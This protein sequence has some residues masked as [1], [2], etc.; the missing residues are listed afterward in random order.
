[1][2]HLLWSI[3]G[4]VDFNPKWIES[5]VYS[6][7]YYY[8]TFRPVW[9]W[10]KNTLCCI[11]SSG[12]VLVHSGVVQAKQRTVHIHLH[13][14]THLLDSCVYSSAFVCKKL[15]RSVTTEFKENWVFSCFW[16][17]EANL[18]WES[19]LKSSEVWHFTSFVFTIY[20][21]TNPNLVSVNSQ[22]L[23]RFCCH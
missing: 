14:L 19:D 6:L 15:V 17:N 9:K 13:E 1:M 22:N 16:S 10:E 12:P 18:R 5:V 8:G 20:G 3:H 4:W 21:L 2:L 11:F 23:L 7:L